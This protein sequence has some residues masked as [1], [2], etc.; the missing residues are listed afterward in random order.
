[1][2]QDAK[3]DPLFEEAKQLVIETRTPSISLVQRTFLLGYGRAASLLEAM[4]G[5]VVST[6]D[7]RGRRRMLTGETKEYL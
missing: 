5:D 2:N 6:M 3:K 1:M 7:R 4:E